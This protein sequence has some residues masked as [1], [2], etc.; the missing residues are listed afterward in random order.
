MGL[1]G[2]LLVALVLRVVV[3]A[4][5]S[6]EEPIGDQLAYLGGAN[7]IHSGE[8]YSRSRGPGYSAFIALLWRVTGD[9]GGGLLAP[10]IGNL[11]LSLLLLILVWAIGRRI[12][13]P[14]VGL[15]AGGF[16]AIHPNYVSFPL[17]L[18]AEN[19]FLVCV[20]GAVYLALRCLGSRWPAAL[21][22]GVVLG[23]GA[24]TREMLVGFVPLL[25]VAV[26]FLERAELRRAFA[27]GFLIVGGAALVILP[28]SVKATAQHEEFVLIGFADGIP[29]FEGNFV[30]PEKLSRVTGKWVGR[31]VKQERW[32]LYHEFRREG[33][34]TKLAQ[35]KRYRE[36]AWK[37]IH[38]RQPNWAFEKLASNLPAMLRPGV[39]TPQLWSASDSSAQ[40]TVTRIATLGLGLPM[41]ALL[42]LL[43]PIGLAR[44]R[45]FG[46][47]LLPLSYVVFAFAV[48]TVANAGPMRFRM[49][50]EWI[51]VLAAASSLEL[52]APIR[53]WVAVSVGILLLAT[54]LAAIPQWQELGS[55]LFTGKMLP[56]EEWQERSKP[57]LER[58]KAQR[59]EREKSE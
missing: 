53:R 58:E 46:P 54:Q 36:E 3:L 44:W 6:A 37:S 45:L 42:L 7:E 27:K 16:L 14:R 12:A 52:L 25:A 59:E 34:R 21:A 56:H 51:F 24:L 28:W 19:L 40:S 18:L 47:A 55:T 5:F 31:E 17:Y 35:N 23:I 10:R 41:H 32:N 13:S 48:H 49:P 57:F 29:L 1:A 8:S 26:V 11:F 9:D 33:A 4:V 30:P 15:I 39:Q 43:L 38:D 2:I 22:T 50:H 20:A